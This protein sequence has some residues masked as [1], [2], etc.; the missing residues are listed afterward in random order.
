MTDRTKAF[1][2]FLLD[3]GVFSSDIYTV[4]ESEDFSPEGAFSVACINRFADR[5]GF[6]FKY[7]MIA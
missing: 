4:S 1:E 7:D 5:R 6:E 2:K 3:G